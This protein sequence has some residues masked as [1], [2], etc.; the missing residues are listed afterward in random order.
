[1]TVHGSVTVR[2]TVSDDR[3]ISVDKWMRNSQAISQNVPDLDARKQNLLV[4]AQVSALSDTYRQK[5]S[6]GKRPVACKSKKRRRIGRAEAEA[7]QERAFWPG[8]GEGL[9]RAS[10]RAKAQKHESRG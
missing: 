1:M 6:P 8:S 5:V 9:T 7:G 4:L 10:I 3:P 2:F